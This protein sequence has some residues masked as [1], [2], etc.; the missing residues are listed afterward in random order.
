MRGHKM[1]KAKATKK[2]KKSADTKVD[3]VVETT[4][5]NPTPTSRPSMLPHHVARELN[6]LKERI[7]LLEEQLE[8]LL[9]S[10]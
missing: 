6:T 9:A 3:V 2:S 7:T 5:S 8:K 4:P 10:K 1:A